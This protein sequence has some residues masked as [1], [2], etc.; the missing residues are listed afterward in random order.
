MARRILRG[1]TQK[2]KTVNG[3]S[4]ILIDAAMKKVMAVGEDDNI[5]LDV[6]WSD[7][8]KDY[9]IAGYRVRICPV[10]KEVNKYDQD[11]CVKCDECL[12]P[13]VHDDPDTQTTS[14]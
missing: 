4:Y 14:E 12:R 11:F 3:S 13:N 6:W 9:Y 1:G 10:C 8:H 5:A 7:K 2:I